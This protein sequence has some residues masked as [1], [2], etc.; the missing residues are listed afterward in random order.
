[1]TLVL[2]L[3]LQQQPH[4]LTGGELLTGVWLFLLGAALF[5]LWC[6]SWLLAYRRQRLLFWLFWNVAVGFVSFLGIFFVPVLG[7]M[8]YLVWLLSLGVVPLYWLT[9]GKP[10]EEIYP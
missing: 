2:S 5:L 9:K 3:V 8:W 1:M 10:R 4:K 6:V 7:I